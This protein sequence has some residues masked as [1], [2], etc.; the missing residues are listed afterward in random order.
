MHFHDSGWSLQ[1][2]INAENAPPFPPPPPPR[3]VEGNVDHGR[4]L[5]QREVT[6]TSCL[7]NRSKLALSL[8]QCIIL[9]FLAAGSVQAQGSRSELHCWRRNPWCRIN[10]GR[11]VNEGRLGGGGERERERREKGELDAGHQA[12]SLSKKASHH[13]QGPE[14]ISR[15]HSRAAQLQKS[16][17]EARPAIKR[18]FS[19]PSFCPG[20][21]RQEPRRVPVAQAGNSVHLIHLLVPKIPQVD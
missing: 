13:E 8:T 6:P 5:I 10:E 17:R 19:R 4:K 15:C 9:H 16:L 14:V 21:R 1:A 20:P 18:P 2:R 12:T 11:E 7:R 3:S